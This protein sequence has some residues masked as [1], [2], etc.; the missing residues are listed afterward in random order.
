MNSDVFELIEMLYEMVS[1]AWTVPLGNDKC[2]VERDKVLD[3]LDE[4][5][6]Q[7]P[8]EID[9]AKKLIA[10]RAEYIASAKREGES[11]KKAAEDYARQAVAEHEITTAAKQQAAEMINA[12]DTKAKELRRIANEYAEDALK[13]TEEAITAAL[14]EIRQSRSSFRVAANNQNQN[15]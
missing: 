14:G 10:A 13:R 3:L 12:A 6:G 2:V 8:G 15:Y 5:K 11:I 9:D 7:L 1:D 4:I